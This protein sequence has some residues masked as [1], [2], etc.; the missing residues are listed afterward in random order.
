M[1]QE[2]I[3][4]TVQIEGPAISES[5]DGTAKHRGAVAQ[6]AADAHLRRRLGWRLRPWHV[7]P[8]AAL[9]TLVSAVAIPRTTFPDGLRVAVGARVASA[10]EAFIEHGAWLYEPVSKNLE[11]TFDALFGSL[12]LVAP[13]VLVAIVVSAVTA[14]RGIGVGALCAT[15]FTW[16]LLTELWEP[17]LETLAFMIVAVGLSAVAGIALGLLG[18]SSAKLDV[19]V[20]L[21]V[22]AMQA[23]PAFAY[24]VPVL[25]VWGIGNPAALVCTIIFAAPPLARMTSVGL[26]GADPDVVEAAVA[27]GAGRRQLLFGVK[28]PLAAHSIHAGLNQTIM[29]AIAMA[30]M[31]AMIGA[32]G[33]GAPVWGGLGRLAFGDALE[34]GIA[35]V[36]VAMLLDRV[37]AARPSGEHKA[38]TV[39]GRR[40]RVVRLGVAAAFVLAT[41]VVTTVFRGPWQNFGDPPWEKTVSLQ[42]PVAAAIEWMNL[43][44]GHGFDTFRDTVQSLGLNPLGSFFQAIPWYVVLV[45]TVLICAVVQGRLGAILGGL[46]VLG[47]GALGMWPSA[48]ATLAVVTTAIALALAIAFPLGVLMSASDRLQWLFKPFLDAMQTLPVYLYVIPSV[49]LLGTGEVAGTISSV[50]AAVPPVIRYTNA[51][52]RGV[53]PEVVEASVML[54]ASRGQILRQVRIPLGLPTL[55][56]GMNQAV[57]VAMA[58]AVV[59]AFIGSP[60]LGQDILYSIQRLDLARGI[61][62]GLAMFLLA[63]I[64]DRIFQ[65]SVRMLSNITHTSGIQEEADA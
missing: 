16:V 26:R 40:D 3:N 53:D 9:V 1:D 60:G 20:R 56:V 32:A 12:A 24:M 55:M 64:I 41:A 43:N 37:S 49:I 39:P 4:E 17:T 10:F 19:A 35:L 15:T 30:T 2:M 36:L 54:G 34:A 6:P 57:I 23:F 59:S 13:P 52:L 38:H 48:A 28:L 46:A 33:L 44:W 47:I 22:D 65:G 31:A 8:M 42:E 62:A 18:A 61:E 21:L 25:V 11:S 58:M 14:Y 63:V 5:V 50:I 27:S 45:C 51:A 7:F 29:Y